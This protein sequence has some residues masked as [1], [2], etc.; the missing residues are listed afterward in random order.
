MSA[1][2]AIALVV[3]LGALVGIGAVVAHHNA[4][5]GVGKLTLAPS[6]RATAPF[7]GF[8][9]AR[10]ALDAKCLRLLVAT[11]PAQRSHDD[12]RIESRRKNGCGAG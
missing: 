11:T 12:R 1:R 10:V 4:N 6:A 8:D 2:L 3:T 5:S 9:E 7:A